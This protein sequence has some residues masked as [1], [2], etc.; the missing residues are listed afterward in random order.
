MM[1]KVATIAATLAIVLA[2]GPRDKPTQAEMRELFKQPA[3][4]RSRRQGGFLSESLN[5]LPPDTWVD[6]C[7]TDL[8]ACSDNDAA[9]EGTSDACFDAGS[10]VAG[11]CF[12]FFNCMLPTALP[13]CY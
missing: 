12:F 2:S 13:L 11:Q 10:K 7:E 3:A 4:A 8:S 6:V 1:L 9:V 5:T